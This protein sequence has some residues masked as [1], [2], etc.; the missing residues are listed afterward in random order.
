MDRRNFSKKMMMTGI[1]LPAAGRILPDNGDQDKFKEEAG[2]YPARVFDV[3]VAGGG[4]AGV[5]AAV[6]AARNGAKTAL[7]EGKGYAGGTVVEG[8]TALHSFFNLWKPFPGVQKR[9]VVKGIA[10]E[11]ID[12]LMVVGGTTGHGDVTGKI[13]YDCVCTAIDTELYKLVAL[14]MLNEAGVSVFTN[15]LVAGAVVKRSSIEG[16]ITQS[17]MGRELFRGRCFVD[18]TAYGDLSAFA[19][20]EY[21]ELNDHPVCNSM[22]L[23]NV[24]IEK[25]YA[26]LVKNNALGDLAYGMRSGKDGQII[27]F[28]S[29]SGY[30]IKGK[31]PQEFVDGVVS[32]GSGLITTTVHD[33]YLMFI[34]VNYKLPVSPTNRDEVAKAELKIRQNQYKTLELFRKYLPGCENAFIARTS[35]SLNIRRG[36]TITCDYDITLADVIE[37]RHFDDDIMVYGFHDS[38]P[39]YQIRNGG[40]YGVPFKALIVKNIDNLLAAGMLITSDFQAHMSTRNTVCCMGQGQAAGTAAALCAS[41]NIGTRDLKYSDLR[42]AL[43]KGNV[44]FES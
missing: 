22:G 9:Q 24:N 26:Y 33:N 12:R 8:G 14:E 30:T 18:S 17:R 42:A 41:R 43:E 38:A 2:K 31:L 7:I 25:L 32:L 15:T 6:A 1:A 23:G 40:T 29:E 13:D 19:G 37:A 35:P 27:R 44:Y 34:K 20:A 28:G 39:R 16:V 5:V 3:V 4:T 36:R 10:Q 21:K 11:I